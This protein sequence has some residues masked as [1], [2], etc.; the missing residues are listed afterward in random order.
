M[1]TRPIYTYFDG[2]NIIWRAVHSD[3]KRQRVSDEDELTGPADIAMNMIKWCCIDYHASFAG[4]AFD[5]HGGYRKERYP[6]YKAGR[7]EDPIL[8]VKVNL[9]KAAVAQRCQA[10]GIEVYQ[11]DRFEADDLIGTL[12]NRTVDQGGKVVII[13]SDK[14]Y[15]QLV[16][17][18]VHLARPIPQ[19]SFSD[20]ELFKPGDIEARYGYTPEQY[21][22]MR[23]FITDLSDNIRGVYR[24]G[25]RI[26][27]RLIQE[28]GTL[29]NV[30]ANI[31]Q[32]KPGYVANRLIDGEEDARLSLWLS[33]IVT[34][35]PGIE[36][37]EK[38][39]DLQLLSDNPTF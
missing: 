27:L 11:D 30:Y 5:G 16:S 15:F 34:D 7:S 33:A 38:E 9:A 18:F 22:Q 31:D 36:P 21:L 1:K 37:P 4:I 17:Q 29:E 12:A 2:D 14:D 13:S 24:I 25:E 6:E 35:V 32:V 39:F 10:I 23:G 28:W 3:E 8:R 19:K 26:A 20:R